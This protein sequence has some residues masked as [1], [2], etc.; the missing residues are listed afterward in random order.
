MHI[1]TDD[2]KKLSMSKNEN[3]KIGSKYSKEKN[4]IMY[5]HVKIYRTYKIDVSNSR[6]SRAC[7]HIEGKSSYFEKDMAFIAPFFHW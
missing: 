5:Q 4:V 3:I 2:L 1:L 6:H 7:Y